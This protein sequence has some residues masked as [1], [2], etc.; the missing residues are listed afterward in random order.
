[1]LSV[2]VASQIL[3]MIAMKLTKPTKAEQISLKAYARLLSAI[4]E[5]KD[6]EQLAICMMQVFNDLS[7]KDIDRIPRASILKYYQDMIAVLDHS[8]PGEPK[9][10]IKIKGTLYGLEPD[11][12]FMERG[13]WVA[14]QELSPFIEQGDNL[15]AVMAILYRP[16]KGKVYK[17]RFY[18]V[19]S[20]VDEKQH[21]YEARKALFNEELTL[22]EVQSC[23]NFILTNQN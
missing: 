22:A 6:V 19:E 3:N 20:F 14:I 18:E 11:I 2:T 10:L 8:Q 5:E 13:A 7:E 16:V 9:H 15:A 4:K 1:M 17:H 21:T 23:L 12:A